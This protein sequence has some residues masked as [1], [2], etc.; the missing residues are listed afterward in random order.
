MRKILERMDRRDWREKPKQVFRDCLK[1]K[2]VNR[3]NDW[4]VKVPVPG[5]ERSQVRVEVDT[6]LNEIDVF[7]LDQLRCSI[8]MPWSADPGQVGAEIRNGELSIIIF[9]TGPKPKKH[10]LTFQEDQ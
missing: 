3:I 4:M 9:K 5:L 2:I 10:V 1:A 7:L 8:L 6:S